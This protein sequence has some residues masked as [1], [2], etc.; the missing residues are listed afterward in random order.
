LNFANSGNA[1]H[2]QLLLVVQIVACV[3]KWNLSQASAPEESAI[4]NV[5]ST[6]GLLLAIVIFLTGLTFN[7][8]QM[9]L[10]ESIVP[11]AI[12]SALTIAS[13][14]TVWLIGVLCRVSPLKIAAWGLT[15]YLLLTPAI[16]LLVIYTAMSFGAIAP[17][18]L[19]DLR[20]PSACIGSSLFLWYIVR[21]AYQSRLLLAGDSRA[22]RDQI[23]WYSKWFAWAISVSGFLFYAALLLLSE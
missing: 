7:I 3:G 16:V 2:Q 20:I 11:E 9:G 23:G 19:L 21:S 15:I 18:Y 17:S 12:E 22:Q 6:L 1:R 4:H 14:T 8:L 13:A 5:D 10:G